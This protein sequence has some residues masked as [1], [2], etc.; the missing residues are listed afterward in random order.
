MTS[1]WEVFAGHGKRSINR[2][3]G[4]A[5]GFQSANQSL[6]RLFLA[7]KLLNS[8]ECAQEVFSL[9]DVYFGDVDIAPAIRAPHAVVPAEV[10]PQPSLFGFFDS[11]GTPA[12]TAP[13]II[14]E[15]SRLGPE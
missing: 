2:C 7:R 6:E 12:A 4:E 3:R 5:L 1:T 10:N 13:I 15:E 11:H 9:L 14:P 8:L